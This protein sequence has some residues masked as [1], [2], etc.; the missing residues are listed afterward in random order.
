MKFLKVLLKYV[1]LFF[2]LIL[3]FSV[4]S[5]LWVL[6]N[7][8]GYIFSSSQD[9]PANEVALVLG[10]SK[11]LMGG[12]PNPYFHY[13]ID[14]AAEL[15]NNHKVERFILSGDNRTRYYNEPNDMKVALMRLGVPD[16]VITLDVAGL[17]T[18]DSV[19]RSKEI[20]GCQKVTIVTQEFHSSRAVFIG[21]Y[22]DI[23]AYGFVAQNVPFNKS[24]KLFIREYFARTKAVL[25][26]LL[27]DLESVLEP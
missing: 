9:I 6:F 11:K 13:R 7:T 2:I 1:F 19:I 5:N 10:T 22:F 20:F 8:R 15:Y 26:V 24:F 23:D 12:K 18:F 17:R 25:D 4:F 16:S 27:L 14:A 3:L 21:K